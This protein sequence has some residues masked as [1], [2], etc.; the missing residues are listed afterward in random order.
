MGT[1]NTGHRRY[2]FGEYT[3]D[4]DRGALL[5]NG[6][7][8]KLRPQSFE[9]LR[10]LVE[11]RGRLVSKDELLQTVWGRTVVTEGSLTQCLVDARRAIGDEARQLIRTV[12]RRGYVFDAPV[13][14]PDSPAGSAIE[15]APAHAPPGRRRWIAA[16]VLACVF[17]AAAAWWFLGYDAF[18][19]TRFAGR[20]NS[21]AV[22][23]FVDMSKEQNQGYFSDG[24]S[25]EILNTLAQ[26]PELLV[27]ARTSS[28][29]FKGKN[30][31]IARIAEMLNVAYILEGSVRPSGDTVRITAQL[32]DAATSAHLWSETYDHN[33][34]NVLA[35]QSEIADAVAEALKVTLVAG[36]AAKEPVPAN[37]EAYRLYLQGRFFHTRRSPGDSERAEAYYRRALEIDPEYGRAWAGL[38]GAYIV[39]IYDERSATEQTRTNWREAV[40][41]A[42]MHAPGLADAHMRAG[43]FYSHTGDRDRATDHHRQALALGPDN[44]LVLSSAAG[45]NVFRGRLDEAIAQQQR[46]VALNP[47]SAVDHSNLMPMLAAAGRL[48]EALAEGQKALDLNPSFASE[49]AVRVGFILI[50]QRRFDEALAAVRKWRG[51]QEQ[52]AALAMIYGA[53]GRQPEADAAL[54]N[55][56]ARPGAETARRVAEVHAWRG[57][58][59]ESFRWLAKGR[60]LWRTEARSER[61]DWIHMARLSPFL[62]SLR[63]DP[64]WEPL[65]AWED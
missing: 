26:S 48:D 60:K 2:S 54:R 15:S 23:P 55:L 41:Q 19:K 43:Q 32:V 28:F 13:T 20:P 14:E 47:L 51:G 24:I 16:A 61:S 37:T 63:D 42:L 38:A 46:A 4:V 21:I 36:G 59:E 65:M 49:F 12:P 6:A 40:E 9:V 53:L 11:H 56:A 45:H 50:A 29:S 57:D 3:L 7:E 31:D 52:D 25:E 30:L 39:Q 44:P 1:E 33:L 62:M 27:I 5:T 58:T 18:D 34:G 8:I 10:Y 17:A 35:V 22:L 64:R